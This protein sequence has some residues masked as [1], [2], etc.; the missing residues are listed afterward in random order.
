MIPGAQSRELCLRTRLLHGLGSVVVHPP[1]LPVRMGHVLV[2]G[3]FW[4]VV[5]TNLSAQHC[6]RSM[7]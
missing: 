2:G 4:R 3:T 6:C 1:T 5:S 7:T